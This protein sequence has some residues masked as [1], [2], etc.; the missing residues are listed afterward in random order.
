MDHEKVTSIIF[1]KK[2]NGEKLSDEYSA[3]LMINQEGDVCE[4]MSNGNGD[5]ELL[6]EG[7]W[8]GYRI[9]GK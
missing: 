2:E 8:I 1:Y 4:L 6:Y 5:Y 7:D 9:E 3:S